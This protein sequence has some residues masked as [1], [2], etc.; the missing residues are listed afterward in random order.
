MTFAL[1]HLVNF[2][3][4]AYLATLVWDPVTRRHL[5]TWVLAVTA[6]A[7]MSAY[8]GKMPNH[9]VPG[10]LF[11]LLGVLA[12]GFRSG[13][14]S[15]RNVIL[16]CVAW[17]FAAFSSWHAVLCIFGWLVMQWDVKQRRRVVSALLWVI[18]TNVVVLMQLLW[19]GGWVLQ[20]SQSQSASYWFGGSD[21]ASMIARLGFLNHALGI[22]IN[23]FA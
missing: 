6:T 5:F 12:W 18:A 8:Y 10:L 3:L 20:D 15:T 21:G 1:L 9:E 23:R 16:S 17:T 13:P 11:F 22:G 14:S 7:P 19:A 4:V 2:A